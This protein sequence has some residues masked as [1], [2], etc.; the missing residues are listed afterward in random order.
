MIKTFLEF[1][2]L[3]IRNWRA[4]KR[5]LDSYSQRQEDLAI[6]KYLPENY[7]S[8]LD[9]GCGNPILESN[10][11][12]LYKRG[13][14]GHMIDAWEMNCKVG[15]FLRRKDTF[16]NFVMN[17]NG[18]SLLFYLFEPYQY[19]TADE[20]IY[21]DLVAQGIIFRKKVVIQ[22][23]RISDLNLEVTPSSP[24][25]LSIDVEGLDLE[26]LNS[27][28]WEKY[29]PRVICIEKISVGDNLALEV[30]LSA[31]NAGIHSLL[32]LQGY[33]LVETCGPSCIYV[34]STYLQR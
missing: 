7:G 2:R 12:L 13:W 25:F 19:S 34:H 28:N 17:S 8:Y 9:I 27:N 3:V 1:A 30:E 5:H 18:E 20:K 4:K 15:K 26:V 6:V 29:L 10:T 11:F 23:K 14:T 31:R 16:G 21:N 22:G 33:K 24:S 32:S